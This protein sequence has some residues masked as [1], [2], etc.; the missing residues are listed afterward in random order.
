MVHDN[1]FGEVLS[2]LRLFALADSAIDLHGREEELYEA[3]L[4]TVSDEEVGD[5]A[6]DDRCFLPKQFVPLAQSGAKPWEQS[7]SPLRR[8]PSP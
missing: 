2:R 7:S 8:P 5:G 4:E 6:N 3:E 1:V